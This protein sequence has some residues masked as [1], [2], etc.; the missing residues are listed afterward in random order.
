MGKTPSVPLL[1]K[2]EKNRKEERWKTRKS[3]RENRNLLPLERGDK[4]G[5]LKANHQITAIRL[6]L[7]PSLPGRETGKGGRNGKSGI[8]E[9]T[10]DGTGSR[11]ERG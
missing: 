3:K 7:N 9:R 6:S 4:R 5:N 1:Q 11:P 10:K 8:R 2:G